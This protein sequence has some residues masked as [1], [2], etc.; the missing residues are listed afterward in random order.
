MSPTKYM[1][2]KQIYET[3]GISRGTLARMAEAGRIEV[4]V[5]EDEFAT[6][7]LY[8]VDEIEK[9]LNGGQGK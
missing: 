5:I 2:A 4:K 9:V 7:K 1:N 8:S 6:L 3:Y